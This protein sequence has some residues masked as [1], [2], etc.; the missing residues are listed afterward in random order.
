MFQV[1][2]RYH[3]MKLFFDNR[4]RAYAELKGGADYPN[5]RG[6]VYFYESSDGGIL[7]EAEGFGLPDAVGMDAP[8]FY[9]FH[10]HENGDCSGDFSKAGTHYNPM[11][12]AHPHHA[13]DL[14]PLLSVDGYAWLAFYKDDLTLHD[15]VGKSV[16]L[17]RNSDD[18]MTQP[19]GGAGEMIACGVI[20][21]SDDRKFS[22]GL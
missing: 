1:T 21:L 16:I 13:G 6:C 7:V 9:G 20:E 18:F 2:P 17:H 3:F 8:A 10:I 15:I 11:R 22:S 14:P 12:R 5:L 4:P 19:S